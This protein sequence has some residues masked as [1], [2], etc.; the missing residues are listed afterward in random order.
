MLQQ[1]SI[2]Q[3]FNYHNVHIIKYFCSDFIILRNNNYKVDNHS[4]SFVDFFATAQNKKS[5]MQ[6]ILF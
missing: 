3:I 4:T 2:P 5:V 6:R 1:T